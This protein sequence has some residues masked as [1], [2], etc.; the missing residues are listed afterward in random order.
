MKDPLETVSVEVSFSAQEPRVESNMQVGARD[1]DDSAINGTVYPTFV[2][3]QLGDKGSLRHYS[4]F[5]Y[6]A[7]VAVVNSEEKKGQETAEDN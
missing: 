5:E 4:Y 3:P 1:R 6:P 2:E 7:N